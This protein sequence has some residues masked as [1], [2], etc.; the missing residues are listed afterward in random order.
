MKRFKKT[1]E[2]ETEDI[3]SEISMNNKGIS[4]NSNVRNKDSRNITQRYDIP[5]RP[6]IDR[7][8]GCLLCRLMNGWS[9]EK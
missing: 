6:M 4:R 9:L 5:K 8:P 3:N 1:E 2:N 7:Q